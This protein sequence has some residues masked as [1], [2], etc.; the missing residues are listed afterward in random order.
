[1]LRFAGLGGV[2]LRLVQ[3][4][5]DTR[6]R[7]RHLLRVPLAWRRRPFPWRSDHSAGAA[8]LPL[9]QRPFPWRSDPFP[10]AMA[11]RFE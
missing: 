4:A 10:G 6:T 9:M 8:T 1:M 2:V 7:C 5:S 11:N 3:Q